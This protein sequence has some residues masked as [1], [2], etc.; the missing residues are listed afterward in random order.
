MAHEKSSVKKIFCTEHFLFSFHMVH[1]D[2]NMYVHP[3]NSSLIS[4]YNVHG[5]HVCMT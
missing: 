5:S 2:F 1:C 3:N 4:Y